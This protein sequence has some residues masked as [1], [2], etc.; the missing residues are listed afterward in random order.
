MTGGQG[1]E[2]GFAI[3]GEHLQP[4]ALHRQ[5]EQ[6]GIEPAFLEAY[7]QARGEFLPQDEFQRRKSL[8]HRDQGLGQVIGTDGGNDPEVQRG[9][10]HIL[11]HRAGE[12]ADAVGLGDDHPRAVDDGAADGGGDDALETTVEE[13]QPQVIL[14]FLHLSGEGGLG[15]V[16]GF[17]GL[18]E[19]AA[20]RQGDDVAELLQGHACNRWKNQEPSI[21]SHPCG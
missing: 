11:P 3:K 9:R 7:Q 10:H 15:D 4:L 14:Q 1:D 19:V 16:A 13:G 12:L 20:I 5:G 8:V 17:R 21:V 18:A 2:E 6:R